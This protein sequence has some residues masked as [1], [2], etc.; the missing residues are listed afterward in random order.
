MLYCARRLHT[1]RAHTFTVVRFI[2]GEKRPNSLVQLPITQ[3]KKRRNIFTK[4]IFEGGRI[5]VC[6][7]RSEPGS[8]T[9]FVYYLLV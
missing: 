3:K 5:V 6:R 9:L 1:I 8:E 7:Q 2:F 4:T